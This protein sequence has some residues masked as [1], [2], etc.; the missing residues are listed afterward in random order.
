[1]VPFVAPAQ[2]QAQTAASGAAPQA[3]G[4]FPPF[5]AETFPSQL[6]WFAVAF[7]LLYFCI[8]SIIRT[9]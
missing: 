8:A 2:A 9:T 1:M 4:A 7:G 3:H 6:L 5:A